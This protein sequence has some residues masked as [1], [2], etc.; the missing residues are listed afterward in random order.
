[1]QMRLAAFAAIVLGAG[2]IVACGSAHSRLPS[3]P[4]VT[5]F[6]QIAF[7]P[8]ISVSGRPPVPEPRDDGRLP[9]TVTP[10]RYALDLS[11]DPNAPRFNGRT[12]ILVDV[13]APTWHVVLHARDMTI[14]SAQ[15][16][17]GSTWFPAT[18]TT[19]NAHGGV[20]PE[21]LV[22]TFDRPL[23]AGQ[24][25]IAIAYSAPFAADLAGLYR[26]QENGLSYA[27]TQFE[28][29]DARRAFP[30]F[31]EP[32][33]KTPFDVRI[34][35]PPGLT[36]LANAPEEA[37]PQKTAYTVVTTFATT[38]PLPTYLV[39][40]AV[41]PFDV[42]TGTTSA[43]LIRVVTTRG[44]SALAGLALETATVLLGQLADYFNMGYPY[45]KLDLLAVPDFGPGAMENPGLVTFRDTLLLVDREHA[46]T[47]IKRTQAQVIAHEF[48]HQ[49]FGDLVTMQWWDDLWLNEG[50]AT[51]AAAKMVDRW[52]PSFGAQLE[53]IAGIQGVMDVDALA[54]ARAVREPVHSNAEAKEAF[55]GIT[56]DKGAAVL[57]MLESYVGADTFRRGIQ[58]YLQENAWKTARADDLFKAVDYVSAQR[59]APLAA[60]F[61][62]QP[63]VPEV[64]ASWT[65]T[66]PKAGKLELRQSEWKPLGEGRP[67]GPRAWTLPVCVNTDG[68]RTKSCFTVGSEPITR[69]LG[70]VCP[71]WV[72]PNAEQAG[73]YRFVVDR[74]K[75]LALSA[76][77]RSLGVAER[78]G[79]VSN[80]W[81]GVRQG[82]IPPRT[83]LD[84]LA[85]FDTDSNRLVID[86]IAGVLSGIDAA[87]I[88]DAARPAF[89]RYVAA[90][91]AT[92]KRALGWEDTKPADDDE[93]ALAR[94]TVLWT[95]G[96][97][98][99]DAATL[100]EAERYATRWLHDPASVPADVAA[101]AVP[102]ASKRA[103]AGR[104]GEL[105]SAAKEAKT[106]QDRTIALRA[107]GMFDDP[108]VLRGALDV[109]LSD[110]VKLSEIR[111][112][113]G[114]AVHRRESFA[115]VY[116][117]EKEQWSNLRARMPGSFGGA[118]LVDVAGSMCSPVAR[119][120]ARAFFV[121]AIDG[122]EGAKRPLDES[123]ERAGLCV[124]LR[125]KSA[126]EVTMYFKSR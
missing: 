9:E 44:R 17:S 15:A 30:C 26:V 96:E 81:A 52:K 39:A 28:A 25:T 55:D 37:R 119:D 74:P 68:Q 97:I 43:P 106:P 29:T 101:V 1:M 48:A 88:E 62:D 6:A 90:R 40:F 70:G 50:F 32:R 64:L 16:R 61:L 69:S 49:W 116:A 57:R 122:I 95:L 107:M 19:R 42:L 110:E 12:Q 35:T 111:Y 99:D 79:L 23:P 86:Q 41:G 5:P 102:L 47:A 7:P 3:P 114:E 59:V 33:Y 93:R 71:T 125:R 76:A 91:L 77:A 38:A 83:L 46:T 22:L 13:P 65:C 84:M 11:I 82:A 113:I 2:L 51:W 21:E 117:W 58:H 63:G 56:Y 66:G 8:R 72:Y 60:A 10:L 14:D 18:T 120:D 112:I 80:A 98:A 36:S 4:P 31:D 20:V 124:A 53:Q 103:G 87:L 123:L 94:R 126:D 92:R 85:T 34:Q 89:R 54:S 104:L 109:V 67:D 75:L 27:Y 108:T 100:D 118:M 115:V 78:M 45:P 105:R 73:Y 24:A 121:P